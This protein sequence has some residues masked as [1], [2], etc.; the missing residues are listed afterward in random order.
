[1]TAAGAAVGLP[2]K[3]SG[4]RE[5][6]RAWST[7]LRW[8]VTNFRLLL[9]VMVAAQILIGAG[10]VLGIGLLF[11]D[12]PL[13]A[14]TYLSTGAMVVTLISVGLIVGPQLVAQQKAQQVY[15]FMWSLPVPR[16]AAASAWITLNVVIAVPGMLVALLAATW[17]Y[18]ID[19]DVT[20][21]IVPAV[22]L[23][24]VCGA[25]LGYALAHAIPKP[26]VTQLI[27]QLLI[28]LV[29]GF[30]PINFPPENLPGWLA[31]VHEVLPFVHM[32]R[33]VRSAMVEGLVTGVAGSYVVLA[34]WTVVAG[35]AA[36]L[37]LRRRR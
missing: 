16:S 34:V 3:R 5:W 28:F 1:M 20:W 15:D 7:M 37:V 31:S 29:V 17:R 10:F 12:I 4:A 33:V 19:F 25:M 32:A 23:T 6:L 27:S 35:V 11:D 22:G 30:A 14:A 8:E 9:P 13:L 24:L 36:A 2:A 21:A 26:D 18:G